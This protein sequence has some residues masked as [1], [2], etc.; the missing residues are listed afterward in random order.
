MSDQPQSDPP[1]IPGH[2]LDLVEQSR[3][4]T[5]AALDQLIIE[6]E[7]AKNVPLSNSVMLP[8]EEFI[9]RMRSIRS[10]VDRLLGEAVDGLPEELRA[11]RWMVREREAYIARTNENAREMLTKARERSEQLV[12]E[13]Y[14]VSEAVEEA[15]T[16]VRNAEREAE[17]IRLEAE[18]VAER[19]LSESEAVLGELLRFV[20]ESRAALHEPLPPADEVPIS[21]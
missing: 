5:R 12:A 15:N 11:A 2:V 10:T 17:R 7:G 3:V 13:S 6:V 9:E 1:P 21:E 8:R 19:A 18:D 14:I 16:L 20:H 4:D